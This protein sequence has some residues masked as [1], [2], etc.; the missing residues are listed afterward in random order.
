MRLCLKKEKERE[1][2]KRKK[3]ERKIVLY[4]KTIFVNRESRFQGNVWVKEIQGSSPDA[5]KSRFCY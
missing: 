5:F 3:F 2:K 4:L 1:R